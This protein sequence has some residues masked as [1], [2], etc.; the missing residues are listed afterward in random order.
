MMYKIHDHETVLIFNK[1]SRKGKQTLAYLIG[2]TPNVR[3]V[4]TQKDS[5]SP[6]YWKE[7]LKRLELHPKEVMDKSL[8]YYQEHIRGR[9]FDSESWLKVLSKNPQLLR[10]PIV[11]TGDRAVLID[12]PSE[13][14]QIKASVKTAN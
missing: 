5:V 10:S 6:S 2:L 1:S 12:N 13:V 9:D 3:Q 8:P 14:S 4:D 11:I 7:I